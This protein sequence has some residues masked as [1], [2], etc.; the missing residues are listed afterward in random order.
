[1]RSYKTLIPALALLGLSLTAHAITLNFKDADINTVIETVAEVTGKNFIVDP[2]VKGQVT[3]IS[4]RDMPPE[5]LYQTFLSILQVHGFAAVPSGNVIKILPETNAKQA[6]GEASQ[7]RPSDDELVTRVITVDHISAPQLVPILRPL[8][9]QYGHLAAYAPANMLIISDRAANVERLARIIGRIDRGGDSSI[10]VVPLSHASATEIVRI[11]TQLQGSEQRQDGT[12]KPSVIA[13][14][15]SNSVL[16]SGEKNDRLSLR[17]LITH[18]DTPL[19]RGGSTQVIYLKYATASNLAT[20]LQGYATSLDTTPAGAES[21]AN[22]EADVSILADEETNSLVITAPTE[23]MRQLKGVIDQLD[24][25]RAQV[26]VEAIIAEVGDNL[27]RNLGVELGGRPGSALVLSQFGGVLTP[28]ISALLAG[29]DAALGTLTPQSGITVGGGVRNSRGD[30]VF[31]GLLNAL[32]GDATTNILSTPSLLTMDNQEAEISVGQEV[33]FV[34]GSFSNTGAN[35]GATNPFTTIQRQDVGITLRITPHVVDENT[36]QLQIYQEASSLS[37]DATTRSGASDLI[38]NKRTI[39]TTVIAGS[40]DVIAL[41]GLID[42]QVSDSVSRVPLLGSIPILGHLFRN[43][44]KTRRR[45][46]L[47]VFIR[48]IIMNEGADIVRYS[49]DR[50][51]HLREAQILTNKAGKD[52]LL[53][54]VG[55]PILQDYDEAQ[56]Q[57]QQQSSRPYTPPAQQRYPVPVTRPTP[58]QTAPAAAPQSVYTPPAAQQPSRSTGTEVNQWRELPPETLPPART[59]TPPPAAAKEDDKTRAQRLGPR[60]R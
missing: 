17:T 19:D 4:T 56:A 18:L 6:G 14:Q 16:I 7:R 27:S 2:R 54:N 36:L 42:D 46:N 12:R 44:S 43:T 57:H 59:S 25:R 21:P 39:D 33:P 31:L 26:L 48:P 58:A 13:D 45:Q 11:V 5:A 47:M 41:G 52:G 3:I 10:D 53:N 60:Q 8:V 38:T 1:M 30:I 15:R 32:S 22:K 28:A 20:I 49:R 50:Y 34:T 37:A 29:T 9:P 40:G 35:S 24:I 55:G 51:D 23:R